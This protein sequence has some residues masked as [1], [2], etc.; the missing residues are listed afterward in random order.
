MG[1]H[2]HDFKRLLAFKWNVNMGGND[3]VNPSHWRSQVCVSSLP[4]VNNGSG[5]LPMRDEEAVAGCRGG[6]ADV[7][8]LIRNQSSRGTGRNA[9]G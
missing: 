3:K 5:Q 9:D 8:W 2:D 1:Q 6:Q 4:F 7:V